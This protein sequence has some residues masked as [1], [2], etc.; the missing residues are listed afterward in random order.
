MAVSKSMQRGEQLQIR[1]SAAEKAVFTEAASISG[2]SV[3]DWVR[4]LARKAA[5][6]ELRQAGR[7]KA[8]EALTK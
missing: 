2:L 8:A 1:V 3:A 7:D 5:T 4:Q 6:L